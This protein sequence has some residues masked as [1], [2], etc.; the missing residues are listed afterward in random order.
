VRVWWSD[1]APG[2]GFSNGSTRIMPASTMP[3]L[4]GL[5]RVLG[6]LVAI[7]I[8]ILAGMWV[9][10]RPLFRSRGRAMETPLDK[11]GET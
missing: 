6:W 5:G 10:G 2:I 9:L 8:A 4:P 7:P 3:R 11:K 1:A